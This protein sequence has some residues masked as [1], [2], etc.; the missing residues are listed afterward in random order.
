MRFPPHLQ[1][2]QASLLRRFLVATLGPATLALVLGMMSAMHISPSSSI[3]AEPVTT[4]EPGLML[5]GRV[6]LGSTSGPGLADV[7]IYR[8]FAAYPGTPVATTD[9]Q[10]YYQSSFQY[11]PGNE[12][13]TVWAEKSGFVFTPTNYSW[14]H[15]FG[16]E[17][18]TLN[19]TALFTPTAFLYLPEIARQY[20]H[21]ATMALD[22]AL[23]L[24][25]SDSATDSGIGA[26]AGQ[27]CGNYYFAAGASDVSGIVA[28]LASRVRDLLGR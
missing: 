9:A 17:S 24:D 10:G 15:Y 16:Y 27:S 21:T 5:Y 22:V 13:V 18:R 3:H 12:T 19:F 8:S 7:T 6:Q 1:F 23:M 25:I 20:A 14:L 4:P 11:I 26:L 2:S 28:D